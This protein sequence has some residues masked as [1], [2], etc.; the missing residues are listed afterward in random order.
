MEG[1]ECVQS[2]APRLVRGLEHKSYEEWHRELSLFILENKR[3]R[4]DKVVSKHRLDLVICKA[5]YSP[6]D[7]VIL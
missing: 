4:R 6:A 5:F 2:K 7:A 3:L 1:L